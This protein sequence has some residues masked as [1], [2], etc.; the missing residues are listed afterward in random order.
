M[1]FA[2]KNLSPNLVAAFSKCFCFRSA[3]KPFALKKAILVYRGPEAEFEKDRVAWD[4]ALESLKPEKQEVYRLDAL[5]AS[6]I[7]FLHSLG[8]KL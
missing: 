4:Q 8:E 2:Q 1:V 7:L 6:E 5:G 3:P